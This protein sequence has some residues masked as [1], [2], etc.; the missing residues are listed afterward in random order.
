MIQI[1]YVEIVK[2]YLIQAVPYLA[3]MWSQS[4]ALT[5]SSSLIGLL[6][7]QSL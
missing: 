2:I 7:F 4:S 5:V 3:M 6:I 1:R